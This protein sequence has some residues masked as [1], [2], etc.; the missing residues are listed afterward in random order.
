MQESY[1]PSRVLDDL[2]NDVIR[3]LCQLKMYF[4]PSFFNIMVHLIVHIVRKIQL[5]ESVFLRWMYQFER[6]MKILKGYAKYRLEASII[7]LY[8]SE[9]VIEF[10]SSYMQSCEQVE[11]VK[12]RV[13]EEW[14]LKVFVEKKLMKPICRLK[15]HRRIDSLHFATH[16]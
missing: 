7:E 6:Y 3:L 9:E 16:W 2:E 8:Q 5:C 11:N 13:F 4:P 10:C 14:R 15:Q 12:V 1:W